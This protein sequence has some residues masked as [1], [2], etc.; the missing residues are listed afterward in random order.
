MSIRKQAAP[1]RPLAIGD[2]VSV[3]S[4]ALG[5]WTAAQIVGLDADSQTAAVLELDWSGPEPSSVADL[6]DVVPLRLTHHS[7]NGA[8]SFCN[9]TWVLPRSHRVLGSLP[10]LHDEPSN[11]WASGWRLGDQLAR[12]RRWDNGVHD[13]PVEA[14]N[15]EYTGVT[16]NEFLDR[17]TAPQS[18]IAQLTIRAID[19]LDCARLVQRFP[20]VVTLHL[21]GRLGLLTGAG[22][23][24]RLSSLQEILVYDLFGMSGEDRLRPQCVPK[25]ESL[26]V[27]S[28]PAEYASATRSTWR[29]EITAGTYVSV[30]RARE[31]AWVEEN[32]NN[33]LRDWDGR[34]HISPTVYKRAVTQYK[35]TRKAILQVFAEESAVVRSTRMEE[36]GRAYGEAFN[37]LDRRTCF[38]ETVERE[39][40]FAALDH[41]VKECE[42]L[43]GGGTDDAH[44]GLISGVESVRDW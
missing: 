40:L 13:D 19:S 1:P 10:L 17:P 38:I 44:A 11:S 22:E 2:V 21:Y 23:L 31:P 25:L 35:T 29:P 12:Q 20:D 39:E 42:T 30:L 9:H 32:R 4:R 37:R 3:C 27:Y 5:E 33:P 24:N 28:V 36:L 34:E 7:W 6:G 15:A 16:V 26:D 43:H 8:L 41:I 14:W 18:Q